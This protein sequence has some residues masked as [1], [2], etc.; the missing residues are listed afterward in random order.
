M[1]PP[2]ALMRVVASTW[3]P[4]LRARP[5][6]TDQERKRMKGKPYQAVRFVALNLKILKAVDRSK[7]S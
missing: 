3:T 5:E 6:I 7:R 1:N 2:E 4:W